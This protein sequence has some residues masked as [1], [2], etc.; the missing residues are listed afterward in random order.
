MTDDLGND[1]NVIHFRGTSHNT[2]FKGR[3]NFPRIVANKFDEQAT[4]IMITPVVGVYKIKDSTGALELIKEPYTL[5]P[6][7]VPIK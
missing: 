6:I 5:K 2:D 7:A 1:Y 3:E 4:S